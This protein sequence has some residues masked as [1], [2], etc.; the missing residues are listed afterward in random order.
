M[1]WWRFRD[2]ELHY[3]MIITCSRAQFEQMCA[4]RG[5]S[6]SRASGCIVSVVGDILALDAD[7]SGYP[8]SPV[9]DPSCPPGFC[10]VEDGF[11]QKSCQSCG[12][13]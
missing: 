9:C 13:N 3:V 4:E 7:H 1:V 5:F 2:F 12:T 10:C 11:G 8:G 6:F